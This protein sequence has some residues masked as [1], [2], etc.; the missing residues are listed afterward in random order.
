MVDGRQNGVSTRGK[1]GLTESIE[2]EAPTADVYRFRT[3]VGRTAY[4]TRLMAF[5]D[6]RF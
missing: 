5:E 6:I 3:K 1:G 2:I 4:L